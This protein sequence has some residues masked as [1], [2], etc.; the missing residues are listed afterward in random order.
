MEEA[1]KRWFNVA[2]GCG[3]AG[4][5]QD[6]RIFP[7]TTIGLTAAK[8]HIQPDEGLG[9]PKYWNLQHHGARHISTDPVHK[10]GTFALRMFSPL[11]RGG[12]SGQSNCFVLSLRP[13]KVRTTGN[14]GGLPR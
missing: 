8:L 6:G 10:E 9:G 4:P 11:P 12:A 13:I 3:P 14:F 7:C 5:I 2:R 1:P